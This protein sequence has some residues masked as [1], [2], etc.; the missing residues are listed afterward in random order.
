MTG[1]DSSR[2]ASYEAHRCHKVAIRLPLQHSFSDYAAQLASTGTA[3]RQC[4]IR[5][6][7]ELQ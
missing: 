3:L 2:A 5:D 6:S 7:L 1:N 4:G